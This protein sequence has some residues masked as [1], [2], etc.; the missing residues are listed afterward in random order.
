MGGTILA[1]R[2]AAVRGGLGAGVLA[3]GIGFAAAAQ[4]VVLG[5]YSIP[6]SYEFQG[7]TG[8][9]L[10]RLNNA[11]FLGGAWNLEAS[12]G[13]I[14]A[15]NGLKITGET[16]GRAGLQ[17]SLRFTPAGLDVDFAGFSQLSF[18][19][20]GAGNLHVGNSFR[21]TAAAF[22]TSGFDVTA[23]AR[24]LLQADAGLSARGCIVGACK[25]GGFGIDVDAAPRL[26]SFSTSGAEPF[27]FG[28]LEYV[29]DFNDPI[30]FRSGGCPNDVDQC[31]VG[32][33]IG[34]LTVFTPDLAT[35]G[36]GGS[37]GVLTART[38]DRL[39]EVNVD[40]DF[41]FSALTLLPQP[42]LSFEFGPFSGGADLVDIDAILA[43]DLV[44]TQTFAMNQQYSYL[45]DEAVEVR[46]WVSRATFDDDRLTLTGRRCGTMR[47]FLP[48]ADLVLPRVL[49]SRSF[50]STYAPLP[51]DLSLATIGAFATCYETARF[52]RYVTT[53]LV[54][55]A[56]DDSFL[57]RS[58]GACRPLSFTASTSVAPSFATSLALDLNGSLRVDMMKADIAFADFGDD[59]GPVYR[60]SFPGFRQ[61]FEV[62]QATQTF[63]RQTYGSEISI[64]C[65]GGV[66]F[67]EAFAGSFQEAGNVTVADIQVPALPDV[68]ARVVLVPAPAGLGLFGVALVGLGLGRRR[69]RPAE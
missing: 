13:K 43:L 28:G 21:H 39:A 23:Q 15:G 4:A 17:S 68:P 36:S 9:D 25:S 37:G 7:Q 67:G 60:G 35:V 22:G 29:A 55:I 11:Q 3:T 53:D 57:L 27:K 26:F 18:D 34:R 56:G 47:G 69:R 59:I 50:G 52:S 51:Q 48:H 10:S 24:F 14:V 38:V 62:Y 64:G 65:D 44:Q 63:G 61:P 46:E 16:S 1:M 54:Q 32:F 66:T 8:P 30:V 6:F 33:E 58:T 5:S 20:D 45:F 19:R 49:E 41:F 42:G 2:R 31:G 12:V 40:V